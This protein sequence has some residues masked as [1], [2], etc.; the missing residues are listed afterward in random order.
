[1]CIHYIAPLTFIVAI[2]ERA[3]VST[4]TTSLLPPLQMRLNSVH[5]LIP[6]LASLAAVKSETEDDIELKQAK[7]I[8]DIICKDED[9]SYDW[10]SCI[11]CCQGMNPYYLTQQG[12]C[13]KKARSDLYGGS[14]LD[15]KTRAAMC[16]D[17][18]GYAAKLTEVV[19]DWKGG[20]KACCTT[21]DGMRIFMQAKMDCFIACDEDPPN[22]SKCKQ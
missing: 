14:D 13:N 20:I 4:L 9:R 5:F 10:Y 18:P 2:Q 22:I 15:A 21:E 12:E 6:L 8:N 7:A 11:M 1:M 19:K 3:H 16:A 17:L